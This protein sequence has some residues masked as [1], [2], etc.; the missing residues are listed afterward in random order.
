MIFKNNNPNILYFLDKERRIVASIKR[1][2]F[3]K[4]VLEDLRKPITHAPMLSY[5]KRN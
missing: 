3:A 5:E 4:A 2:I 1:E